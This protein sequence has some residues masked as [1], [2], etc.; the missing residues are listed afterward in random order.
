M[1][2]RRDSPT[3]RTEKASVYAYRSI[4]T[5]SHTERLTTSAWGFCL[6]HNQMLALAEGN[7]EVCI[8]STLEEGHLTYGECYIPGR[9]D[10]RSVD[11][12]ACLSSL[13]GQ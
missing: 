13:A 4:R 2:V 6:S 7:Y 8:D 9:S 11:L 12:D 10:R 3:E 1:P 5:G